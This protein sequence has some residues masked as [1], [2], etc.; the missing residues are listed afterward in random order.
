MPVTPPSALA[1]AGVFTFSEALASGWTPWSLD[2]AIRSGRLDRL[3]P[4]VYRDARNPPDGKHARRRDT[5]LAAG[6]AVTASTSGALMSH[7]AAAVARD[8]PT[9]RLPT[10]PCVTVPP[11]FTGEI[12]GAHLHR[13]TTPTEHIAVDGVPCTSVERTVI[14]IAREHGTL[15]ALVV[16]DAALHLRLTSADQLRAELRVCRGW[17]GVRAA[18]EAIEFADGRSESPLE[19]ASRFKLDGRVPTPELQA[20]IYD[21]DGRFL[22]RAD[23]LWDELGVVGEADGADKFDRRLVT[24]AQEHRRQGLFEDA[25]LVVGRWAPADLRDIDALVGR[26]ENRF[27]LARR[28]AMPRNWVARLIPRI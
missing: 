13:A 8:L 6:I 3:R 15:D 24:P 16:A 1:R 10:R 7:T 2:R 23:F 9:W 5:L 11:G 25:G 18:R 27:D 22:G 4:G 21:L 19:S 28:R 20:S 26:L 17:P 14:D 12:V